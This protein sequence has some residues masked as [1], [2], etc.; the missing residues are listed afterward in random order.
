M[1]FNYGAAAPFVV[2]LKNKLYLVDQSR[3]VAQLACV[4]FHPIYLLRWFT[5]HNFRQLE[6]NGY[7]LAGLT[8]C[9]CYL[10]NAKSS[11]AQKGQ[12]ATSTKWS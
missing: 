2:I 4:L 3:Y 10:D 8:C 11:F 5:R 12:L 7:D 1:V 6:Q 9:G